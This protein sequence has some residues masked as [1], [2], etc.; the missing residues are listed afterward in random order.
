MFIAQNWSLQKDMTYLIE[1]SHLFAIYN[2]FLI[3]NIY[4]KSVLLKIEILVHRPLLKNFK[5][6]VNHL[7]Y[8]YGRSWNFSKQKLFRRTVSGGNPSPENIFNFLPR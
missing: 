4:G 7:Q 3:G 6:G 1:A 5:F 2:V 8:P